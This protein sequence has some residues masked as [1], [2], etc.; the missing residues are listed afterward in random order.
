MSICIK[1]DALLFQSFKKIIITTYF[2]SILA[3]YLVNNLF[4]L[5]MCVI[6]VYII[7]DHIK[8]KKHVILDE[9]SD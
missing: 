6:T 5:H 2:L 4:K 9:A 7:C 3:L 8:K 1:L